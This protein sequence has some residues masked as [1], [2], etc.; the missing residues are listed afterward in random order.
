M[1]EFCFQDQGIH[2]MKHRWHTMRLKQGNIILFRK[3]NWEGNFE[4]L[5]I[6]ANK[7]MVV[8]LLVN[9]NNPWGVV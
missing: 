2:F 5:E 4:H 7:N 3:M 9:L 1:P 8:M 6:V